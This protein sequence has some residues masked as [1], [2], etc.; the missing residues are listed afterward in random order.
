MKNL[1]II[2]F[3]AYAKVASAD[4]LNVDGPYMRTGS[5]SE[6]YN[7]Q[8][9]VPESI[10]GH[11]VENNGHG[12]VEINSLKRS[13]NIQG[14]YNDVYGDGLAGE[15]IFFKTYKCSY[16]ILT[17][18]EIQ[19]SKFKDSLLKLDSLNHDYYLDIPENTDR[20]SSRFLA[21]VKDILSFH[22]QMIRGP[23]TND[24]HI[25]NSEHGVNAYYYS[26]S[27]KCDLRHNK[28]LKP[29]TTLA[30]LESKCSDEEI[31]LQSKKQTSDVTKVLFVGI[32]SPHPGFD[33][34]FN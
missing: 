33:G 13:K 2:A 7:I 19:N 32:D 31:I 20:D 10:V 5:G 22:P 28:A 1:A 30:E 11:C 3:M 12:I 14:Q 34:T 29:A 6:Y 4:I 21:E 23:F 18:K 9:T 27:M 15:E 25:R 26:L 8:L 17:L 16:P 24:V